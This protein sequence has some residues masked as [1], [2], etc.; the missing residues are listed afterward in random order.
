MT[1]VDIVRQ[2]LHNQHLTW[3]TFEKPGAIVEWMAALQGQDYAGAKWS[4]GLRLPGSMDADIEQAISDR[5]ILRT[6][7]MRGTLHFVAATDMR[8]LVALIAP[9]V[10]AGNA[11]RYKQ[12]ELDDKTLAQSND[13]IAKALQDDDDKGLT[14]KELFKI[15]EANNIS[16]KGQRGVYMLQRASLDN[17]MCQGVMQGR[18]SVFMTPPKG[19]TMAH[20]EAAAELAK[21]Y[22]SSRGPATLKDFTWWS[23]LAAADARAGLEAVK[24]GLVEEKIN[25]QSYWR[26]PPSLTAKDR[27]SFAYLLPGFDEYLLGYTDRSDVLDPK[28]A[29]KVLPGG[30]I[31]SSTIVVDGRVVGTWKRTV[32]KSAIVIT[33]APFDRMTTSERDALDSATERYGEFLDMP[34]ILA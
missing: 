32:K 4:V 22:F 21:R 23:G 12:L 6:W 18:E 30:G 26:S 16:T 27:K 20:D 10:R 11:R 15:L 9:R 13:V 3:Q 17:L 1:S 31:F 25:G 33:P 7:V 19:K 24:A 28:H 29:K 34:A 2:R 8:W 14:R 5:R